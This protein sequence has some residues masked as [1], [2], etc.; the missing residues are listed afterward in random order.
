M[1]TD[2]LKMTFFPSN[3]LRNYSS[4][5]LP[6]DSY[7]YQTDSTGT[8]DLTF[9]VASF[10]PPG[11]YTLRLDFNG[12]INLLSYPYSFYFNLPVLSSSTFLVNDLKIEGESS[13]HFW[14]NGTTSD[15]YTNPQINRHDDLNLTAYIHIA[16]TPIADGELVEFY[17]VTQDNIN[18]YC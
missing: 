8:F 10:T 12:T 4:F 9:G 13:L 5:L 7:P 1:R 18:I 16:G 3:F 14:I 17:D 11:N 15:D 6:V 2:V